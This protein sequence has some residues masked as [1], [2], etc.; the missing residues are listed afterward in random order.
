MSEIRPTHQKRPLF[1][2]CVQWRGD[3]LQEIEEWVERNGID[4]EECHSGI[5]IIRGDWVGRLPLNHW[6]A[7]KQNGE[8][9]TYGNEQFNLIYEESK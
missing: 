3:N 8:L 5:L 6:A 4:V 7:I 2:D 1:A 9:K